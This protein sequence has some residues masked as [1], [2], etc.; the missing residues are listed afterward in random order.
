VPA[1]YGQGVQINF[2]LAS[3]VSPREWLH[4]YC[5]LLDA[6]EPYRRIS[7]TMSAWPPLWEVQDSQAGYSQNF[8]VV[9]I[10]NVVNPHLIQLPS[11]C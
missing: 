8:A 5:G 6:R 2:T 11:C 3:A 10:H 7:R 4:L 9:N 1:L